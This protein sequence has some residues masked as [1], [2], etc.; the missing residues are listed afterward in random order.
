[1]IT[2]ALPSTFLSGT[3][4][5]SEFGILGVV[6]KIGIQIDLS[7]VCNRSLFVGFSNRAGREKWK[8]A[9]GPGIRGRH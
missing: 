7:L 2:R 5:D 3:I 8:D 1:M 6:A 9:R 4:R